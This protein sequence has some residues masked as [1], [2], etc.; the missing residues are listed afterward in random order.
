MSLAKQG[1]KVLCTYST[2]NHGIFLH[3]HHNR[4]IEHIEHLNNDILD[5]QINLLI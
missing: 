2:P 5:I 1:L 4:D 3:F